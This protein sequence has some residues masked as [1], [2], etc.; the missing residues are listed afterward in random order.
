LKVNKDCYLLKVYQ[1]DL[2]SGQSSNEY[3][4]GVNYT[5]KWS[6]YDFFFDR[7]QEHIAAA[8]QICRK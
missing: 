5:L 1:K 2:V 3:S 7:Y 4:V 6:T 8:P